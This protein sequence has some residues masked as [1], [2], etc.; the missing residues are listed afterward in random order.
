MQILQEL[1]TFTNKA[2]NSHTL[3]ADL[4]IIYD[5]SLLYLTNLNLSAGS[6]SQ[7]LRDSVVMQLQ[8]RFIPSTTVALN[9]PV[10]L[11]IRSAALHPRHG[12]LSSLTQ[13]LRSHVWAAVLDDAVELYDHNLDLSVRPFAHTGTHTHT[14]TQMRLCTH[15]YK[16]THACTH[17]QF[18]KVSPFNGQAVKIFRP[19]L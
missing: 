9:T 7:R 5:Q 16:H 1:E 12:H 17:T 6:V 10:P 13:E 2:Q 4:P 14:P 18:L 11:A 15:T 3:L 8:E 19:C